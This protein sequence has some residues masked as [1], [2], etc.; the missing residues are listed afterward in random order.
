MGS[1][2]LHSL[3]RIPEVGVERSLNQSEANSGWVW[4]ALHPRDKGRDLRHQKSQMRWV[5]TGVCRGENLASRDR[6][7]PV[8]E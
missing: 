1:G 2:S 8:A 7:I 4:L 3:W 6:V 5:E